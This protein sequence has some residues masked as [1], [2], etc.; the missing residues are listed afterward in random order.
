MNCKQAVKG[1]T[2]A[3]MNILLGKMRYCIHKRL[4]KEK[5]IWIHIPVYLIITSLL[6]HRKHRYKYEIKRSV[7]YF[8]ANGYFEHNEEYLVIVNIA[9]LYECLQIEII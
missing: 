7:V 5:G 1:F 9:Y 4:Q 3:S 6:M 8:A 2:N